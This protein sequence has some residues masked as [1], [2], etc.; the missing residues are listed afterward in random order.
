MVKAIA[1]LSG[2]LDSTLA[3]KIVIQQ[4]IEVEAV[5]FLTVF[6]TCTPKRA[7]CLA[8]KRAAEQLGIPVKVFYISQE[9][10]E[11]VKNP[12]YG[13][14]SNLNPCIDCRIFMFK[15]AREYMKQSGASFIITGEV[16]HERPMSQRLQAMK[17]IETESGLE[18][19][20]LRP[21]S[22][23]LL[24]PT[25]PE[26]MGWVKR[27]QL[28]SIKGRSRKPQIQL[29]KQYGIKDYPCPAGG[30]LLTDPGFAKRMNDLMKHK[31]NFT[32]HDV[33]LLKIGRHFRLSEKTK[34]IVCRNEEESNKI[35]GMITSQDIVLDARASHGPLCIL[36]GEVGDEDIK[37]SASIVARYSK[38]KQQ[39]KVKIAISI[40]Y[41][42]N[43]ENPIFA[44]PAGEDTI[45]SL[46]I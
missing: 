46:I 20:I 9:Y 8:S 24:K 13:Y 30:C 40:P 37:K 45:R 12:K 36:T 35:A 44:S 3:A 18:G 22:A 11:I 2:G 4:G 31:P 5:N 42:S 32:L 34:L 28:L 21:L 7:S 23:K 33:N 14:G 27:D 15:K 25:I 43:I 29:A 10:L 1:L 39:N 6:C 16:L 19:L 26:K 38:I 17:I 41:A